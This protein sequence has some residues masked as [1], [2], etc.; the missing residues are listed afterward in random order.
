MKERVVKLKRLVTQ[1]IKNGYSPNCPDIINGKFILSLG[2]L[3]GNG[4]DISQVKPAPENDKKVDQFLLYAGDFLVSRSNTIDKVG[5]AALFRG[6]IEN[7][8]YPD[9]MMRFRVDEEMVSPDY[10]DLY[11]RS[12]T[13]IR[14]FQK[15]ASGT[16]ETMVKI[17][18]SVLENLP[19][20]LPSKRVQHSIASYI[21]QW[22]RA[23]DLTKRLIAAKQ[24]LRK[25][26]MQQ[27]LTGK[28]R[29]PGSDCSFME[30]CVGD[31]LTVRKETAIPSS[32]EPL[33][34]LTIEKGIT[35]KTDR[36]NR[37]AL[38][39]DKAQ[40]RYKKVYPR[41]IVFNPSNLRWGAISISRVQHPVLVSPIYEV[42]Y[43]DTKSASIDYLATLLCSERQIRKFACMAEGTL[44]E[45][46]AVKI[47]VFLKTKILVPVCIK[48]QRRLAEIFTKVDHE[49][50]LLQQ[51]V[52]A[53]KEQKNGL[54]Q[55][56]LTGKIRVKVPENKD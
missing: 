19:V 1:P 16:S 55:Q 13:A 35:P 18:K 36:Y 11:L 26:L 45:R 15:C 21:R 8:S 41:D 33:Y 56:L 48:Y 30:V 27:L 47:D 20:L 52:D 31:V 3:S 28:K 34:S 40:K 44:V 39:K 51:T 32:E 2:A 54:I 5:R 43:L 4:I 25:G 42:L 50:R 7:C 29:L 53:L 12:Q 6:E 46:T 49:I 14:Y 23:I 24:K 22:D 38:V 9:L 37:E 10:L 17:N